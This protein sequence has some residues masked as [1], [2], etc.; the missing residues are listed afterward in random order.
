[1]R[2][3]WVACSGSGMK[4]VLRCCKGVPARAGSGARG[5]SRANNTVVGAAHAANSATT[6]IVVKDVIV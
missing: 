6:T 3:E 2:L 4:H 1:L 5:N